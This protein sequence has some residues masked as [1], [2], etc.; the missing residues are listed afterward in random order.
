[1]SV[2][3]HYDYLT[4]LYNRKG[5]YEVWKNLISKEEYV[6]V[7]FVDLDNFKT[8]NDVYG[9][10]AGDMT[11]IR[12]AEILKM[13]T[14]DSG[15]AIRLGGDEFV[16]MI[17][18]EKQQ[19]EVKELADRMMFL[20]RNEK[21]KEKYFEI[22]S[23]SMGIVWNAKVADDIDQLLSYSDAAMYFAKESGK[24][25]YIFFDDFAE[26][27]KSEWQMESTAEAA[28]AAGRFKL[29]YY[30]VMHLQ[31]AKLLRSNSMVIWETEE[32]RIWNRFDFEHVLEK[33]GMVKKI[34]LFSF[35]QVCKDFSLLRQSDKRKTII[36]VRLSQLLLDESAVSLL[37]NLTEKYQVPGEWIELLL[38]EKMFGKRSTEYLVHNL[39]LLKKAGFSIGLM[40]FGSDF[41]SI[42][43]LDSLPVSI[44][45][46]DEDFI[47]A[48]LQDRSGRGILHTLFHLTKTMRFLSIAQ[49]V[50]T[51]DKAVRL[52]EKGCEGAFGAYFSKPL[53]LEK[54]TGFIAGITERKTEQIYDFKNRLTTVKEEYPGEIVGGGVQY[55]S[56]IS[57]NWGGLRFSG[58]PVETNLVRLPKALFSDGS[59]SVTMWIRPAEIQN[60][61]SAFFVRLHNGFVSF[62]PTISG[63][64]CMFRMHSD[65][66]DDMWTDAMSSA[67]PIGKWSYV[68]VVYD[69]FSRTSRVFI[70]GEFV[71]SHGDIPELE[72]VTNVYL[73]GDS[74]QVSFRG[75]ISA[76]CIYDSA[77][78]EEEIRQS[79]LEYKKEK[80]FHGD[81][82]P[83]G[84]AEYMVHD[85]AVYEDPATGKFYLYC[86]GAQGLVSEDLE[87]WDNLGT[88]VEGV[89]KEA[90]EWT[91]SDAIWAPD[92]V[93][94]GDEY[95][96]YC[97]NSSW[98]VQKSCIFLATSDQAEGPF[99]PKNVVLKTD[100]TLV[101]NGIDANIIEAHETGEQYLLYGSFWDGIYLLPLDKKTGLAKNAGTDGSG[102]GSLRLDKGYQE[103][104]HISELPAEVRT[105]RMGVCLARR[106]LWNDGALEG[107]YMI[108]YPATGYYYLFV[109]YGSLKSDYNIRVGRSKKPVG[110]FLDYFGRDLADISDEN[111]SRGLLI[112]AG[113]RWLNGMPYMGPGHNSVLQRKNGELFM[114]SHIRKMQ[115]MEDDP[116]VGLLQIRRLFPTPDGWFIAGAQPYAEETY[117]IARE[118]IVPGIYERIELRPS[119]PQ[120][121]S[122]AHPLR[123]F[124]N[125]RL[126]CCSV[127]GRWMRVDDFTLEFQYG[128]VREYVHIEK[129]LD[130]DINK[131]TVLLSGLTSQGICTWAKK[132]ID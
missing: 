72:G 2:S 55:I 41:S 58:G 23:V 79:Y 24:N 47:T 107:P 39:D 26:Q 13:T 106:P 128:P 105:K 73:G 118:H 48:N 22:I 68:A 126:E 66:K 121:I 124:E 49:G 27:I 62:M 132:Q 67:L 131:T 3:E 94:V 61:I 112:S 84:M 40:N 78:T 46:F 91:G 113:Y 38:D 108:Y 1:M 6:Q 114:V 85:P 42:R 36:G 35:E 69:D 53:P 111:C 56:G 123:L 117:R 63:N 50:E 75:D 19:V 65:L 17:P 109:S 7:L 44:V 115:F 90:K 110:P 77:K 60:W 86:T 11:L 120:G 74:Y 129:G 34:D 10:K 5:M 57:D 83:L 71:A 64:L 12:V 4:G 95:R 80:D 101:V 70:D 18:G 43:F 89:P 125:G 88:I 100:D 103:G 20:I 21:T 122:H 98:G 51:S 99:K 16:V 119:I 81:D 37:E 102:V 29:L 130:R 92:I 28:L 93:K 97:S 30:P 32:G 59:F 8:V 33:S 82:E 104:M 31:N 127:I 45:Y 9:H 76:L 14:P 52:T 96:L 87:H 15:I 116:G 25:Q 54:Y